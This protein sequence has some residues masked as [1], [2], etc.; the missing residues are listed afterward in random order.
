MKIK[1][2]YTKFNVLVPRLVAKVYRVTP[3]GQP[4]GITTSAFTQA[5]S[6]LA[7][8]G[9]GT[10][11]E[12]SPGA[13][14]TYLKYDST[15]PGGVTADIPSLEIADSANHLIN[16]GFDFA[17]RQAPGTLTTIA[18]GGYSA[19]RWMIERENAD[20]QYIR[21]DAAGE[22]GLTCRY[23]G[24]FKKIT[25]AGKFL[26][27][28]PLEFADSIP[29][30]GKTIN[31]QVQMKCSDPATVKISIVQLAAAGTIDTLPAG[32]VAA[33]GADTVNPTLGANLASITTPVSCD[34]ETTWATFQITA[35]Y[36]ATA[37]NL[38]VMI[39]TDS[40]WVA[41]ESLSIA[42][43]GLYYG[44]TQRSWT[45]RPA[46]QELALAERYCT[47]PLD[48][49]AQIVADG[50]RSGAANI[51]G[52]L[53]W[54][55]PL[56]AVPTVGANN[57]S[58]WQAAANPATTE[59]GAYDHTGGAA[60]TITGALTATIDQLTTKQGRLL[61]TAATS[62]SGT[63]GDAVDIRLGPSVL[64]VLSAEL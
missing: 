44:P 52:H 31:F 24:Q 25:N 39:W 63:A 16:G 41:D 53:S 13:N 35:D 43:A 46:A 21:Q 55:A 15:A 7:G 54:R 58:G 4:D 37:K 18:D 49:A 51:V 56:R 29:F 50:Y 20:L 61:L 47:A 11:I 59:A 36:P 22:T 1:V 38:V 5:G 26:I 28:Q 60:I 30:R 57:I 32:I 45:P 14:G 6:L 48:P 42:E 62:F 10:Y 27:C 2:T 23:Y 8:T 40:D 3:F 64:L 34:V 19:D 12:K 17:Q 9:A 33:W